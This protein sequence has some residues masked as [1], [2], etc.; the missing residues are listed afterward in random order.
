MNSQPYLMISLDLCRKTDMRI[1]YQGSGKCFVHLTRESWRDWL[2]PD[3]KGGPPVLVPPVGLDEGFKKKKS[4]FRE[5]E[6]K[7]DLC[8]N[9]EQVQ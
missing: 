4:L 1:V 8:N 6:L 3:G 7:K 2:K 5:R 9:I